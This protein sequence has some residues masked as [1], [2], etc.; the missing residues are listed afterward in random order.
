MKSVPHNSGSV[1]APSRKWRAIFLI[2]FGLLIVISAALFFWWQRYQTTPAYTLAL[3]VDAAQQNDG[4]AFDQLVD[5]D[6]VVD[7]FMSQMGQTIG[8]ISEDSATAVRTRLQSVAP[9]V[10]ATVRQIIREETRKQINEVA[11]PF[12]TRPFLLMAVAIPFKADISQSNEMA[13]VKINS[14]EHKV[15]LVL[16]RSN[17]GR[18]RVVS[19]RDDALAARIATNI[20]KD[21]PGTKVQLDGEIQKRVKDLPDILRKLPVLSGK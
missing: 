14:R 21:L 20:L 18:W 10:T 11:S 16:E 13:H 1:V 15:E 17:D 12:S 9:G 6:R 8:G 5:M 19:L 7:N 4:E 3:L 2:L